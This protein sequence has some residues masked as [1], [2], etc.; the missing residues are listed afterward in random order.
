M[1][2]VLLNAVARFRAGDIFDPDQGQQSLIDGAAELGGLLVDESPESLAAAALAQAAYARGDAASASGIMLA[3]V[4]GG[5]APP[6]TGFLW[7][8]SG[9]G[10]E[11]TWEG[12]VARV[13]ASDIP[14]SIFIDEDVTIPA[15]GPYPMKGSWIMTR[16]TGIDPPAVD[17][18][19]GAQLLDL[20][21]YR[22]IKPTFHSTA[23]SPMLFTPGSGFPTVFYLGSFTESQNA[24]SVPVFDVPA[25][26]FQLLIMEE[27]ASIKANTGAFV[28][29]GPNATCILGCIFNN[30]IDNNTV[31]SV[32]GTALLAYAHL[33]GA[34]SP[35]PTNVPGFTGTTLNEPLVGLSWTT[36]GRPTGV[37]GGLHYGLIGL[38]T[39]TGKWEGWNGVAWVLV[40][41]AVSSWNFLGAWG[42]GPTY[43]IND[44]VRSM[45]SSWIAIAPSTNQEPS[46]SPAQ[47]TLVAQAGTNGLPGTNGTSFVWQG[48]WGVATNYVPNDVVRYNGSSYVSLTNNVGNQPDI[49]PGAWSLMAQ[50]G[51][52]GVQ[53]NPGPAGPSGIPTVYA[54]FYDTLTSITNTAGWEDLTTLSVTIGTANNRLKCSMSANFRVTSTLGPANAVK[55]SFRLSIIVGVVETEIARGSQSTTPV[56]GLSFDSISIERLTGALPAG[57]HTLKLQWNTDALTIPAIIA[58][59]SEINDGGPFHANGVSI[60]AQEVAA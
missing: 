25:T 15:G 40:S 39:D 45:G 10:D 49:T 30:E 13:E 11:T 38:N 16:I 5:S 33:G 59:T 27:G 44:V 34:P 12:A 41:P 46:V 60:Q 17:V 54:T 48:L 29:I 18:A 14:L 36:A 22:G 28:R 32:D 56:A 23:L 20:G 21:G 4:G 19:D 3:Q 37:L 55:T 47:W 35:L 6:A 2:K 8:P 26:A 50:K 24:G 1:R 58:E 53:G 7:K 57:T 51:D 52:P 31:S 9:G 42:A 43:A